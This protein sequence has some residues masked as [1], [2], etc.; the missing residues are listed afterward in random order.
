M[1]ENKKKKGNLRYVMRT[2]SAADKGLVWFTLIKNSLEQIFYVFFF[3][4]LTKYIFDCIEK[5]IPYTKLFWFLVIACSLHICIHFMCG[6]YECYRSINTPKI[7][8]YIFHQVM[9]IS[10]Q[11][12][13]SEYEDPSFYDA[14]T[15]ALDQCVDQAMQLLITLGKFI[16]NIVA[17]FLTMAIV[18]S[19]DPMLMIMVLAPIGASFYFSRKAGDYEFTLQQEITRAKREADYVKRVFY[20]KKYAGELRLYDMQKLLL[21]RQEEA[22]DNAYKTSL[23]YRMKVAFHSFFAFGSYSIMATV[24]A[25][26]YVAFMVKLGYKTNVASYI[27]MINALAFSS[28]QFKDAM[29]NG[30]FVRK[31]VALFQNLR[32]F[33]ETP[34]KKQQKLIP[35]KD[36][37]E[38]VFEH[39]TFRYPGAEKPVIKDMNFTWKKGERI[40]V[41]G[42]NGAG[43]TTLVKLLMGLYPV[44]EGRILVNGVDLKELDKDEYRA[45][46]GTVF[47]DLQVFA[48]SLAEN[49]LLYT[50]KSEEDYERAANA[51]TKA[52]FDLSHRGLVK[53][54][55]TVISREFDEEGF[56]CSGGQAQ[57]IAIARVFMK[58]PD[59]VIL[60]EPSSA[61][62]PLAEYNMYNN[63]MR[64]SEG[65][66]VIFISHRLSSAR[67][68]QHIFMMKNGA[69]IEEGSHEELM[70]M[71]GEYY[72]MFHLQAQNYQESIPEELFAKGGACFE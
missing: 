21:E 24:G 9:D 5:S 18:V 17:T 31:Q 4:Y 45:H 59:M 62:D 46:F 29:V 54:L 69:I 53:G 2:V 13:I 27:A 57:K 64:A 26:V 50:P 36:V 19:V 28:G 6:W 72:K 58:N 38:I 68:A 41:V 20:E 60:D 16:G 11:I 1:K 35:C 55:D 7:Y 63:M 51:L 65:K 70:E 14:Y 8:R 42:Y 67:M 71:Q 48:M 12:A 52:Q 43:K 39:V 30:I 66:G 15:K 49:V 40:A 23:F 22:I 61:L 32:D 33:L 10:D 56:V 47:Q 44:T 25:Y 3:V 37:S 34:R